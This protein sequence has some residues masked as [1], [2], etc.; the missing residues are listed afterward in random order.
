[1]D[2]LKKTKKI[3]FLFVFSTY[4]SMFLLKF[5]SRELPGCKIKFY[6][7][8]V[9]TR[10]TFGGPRYP[11]NK[12]YLRK[13]DD[14]V[15]THVF[16]GISCFWGS[17]VCQKY[18]EWVLVMSSPDWN[19]SKNMERYVENTNKKKFFFYDTYPQ[20]YIKFFVRL[21]QYFKF[22]AI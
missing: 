13:H 17:G 16:S 6:I 9:P 14:D 20:I 18:A 11:Q 21:I 22:K 2:L 3:I 5:R 10:N 12:K 19:L 4:L 15:I 1:M 8:W 7:Q